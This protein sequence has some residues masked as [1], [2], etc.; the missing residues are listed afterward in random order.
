MYTPLLRLMSG[1]CLFL[2]SLG[3][4]AQS[5]MLEREVRDPDAFSRLPALVK[6]DWH[7]VI[8]QPTRWDFSEPSRFWIGTAS[9]LGIAMA[10]DG[11]LDHAVARNSRPSWDG[12]ARKAEFLGGMGSVGIAGGA[13]LGGILA[14]NAELRA[15]G[16]DAGISM[17]IAQVALVLPTKYAIG[18]SRPSA[19]QGSTHFKPFHGGTSFPSGHATQ[20]FVL[21]SVISSHA[22]TPW[23]SVLSYSSASIVGLSRME[24]RHH[25]LSDVVGGAIIGTLIG[26]TVTRY[27]QSFRKASGPSSP[28]SFSL[29]MGDG[30]R[31]ISLRAQF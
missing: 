10:A 12:I 17:A 6:A 1:H 19:D 21:A 30:Y 31:G 11:P 16:I 24:Q 9:L 4:L 8:A 29:V 3:A 13:Y 22:K 18:R 2:V 7:Q 23:V 15:T 14:D 25:F 20:A 28:V 26:N 27:N 5:P